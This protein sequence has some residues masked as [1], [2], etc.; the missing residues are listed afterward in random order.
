MIV[1]VRFEVKADSVGD[2]MHAV[3]KQAADSFALEPACRRFDV[4][5]KSDDPTQV[6]LYEIYDSRADFDDHLQSAHF[7]GFDATVAGWV[8]AKNVEIWDGPLA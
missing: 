8:A 5:V 6:L 1:V 2:F 7:R 3:R 4:A